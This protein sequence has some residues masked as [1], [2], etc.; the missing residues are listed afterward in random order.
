MQWPVWD[1]DGYSN[2]T[3]SFQGIQYKGDY[4]ETLSGNVQAVQN[5]T[6]RAF[7]LRNVNTWQVSPLLKM[8]F[9]F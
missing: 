9:E 7:Q 6:E 2:T 1:G 5:S 4:W 3:V 8:E